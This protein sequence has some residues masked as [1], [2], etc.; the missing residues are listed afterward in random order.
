M[1]TFKNTSAGKMEK[2]MYAINPI[3]KLPQNLLL[4]D[5][6][7]N[8][9]THFALPE[10]IKETYYENASP[11]S[12]HENSMKS[13][14]A[15]DLIVR[16]EKILE[17]LKKIK[18]KLI[19]LQQDHRPNEAIINS[20]KAISKTS[21]SDGDFESLEENNE[22]E[23]LD[24]LI[25]LKDELQSSS[26]RNIIVENEKFQELSEKHDF[27]LEIILSLQNLLASDI[28][29]LQD[30]TKKPSGICLHE[31]HTEVLQ[32]ISRLRNEFGQILDAINAEREIEEEDDIGF[33][34]YHVHPLESGEYDFDDA[35]PDFG[36]KF[37]K[38]GVIEDVVVCSDS[39]H[40][41]Y[42][43]LALKNLLGPRLK[44]C[45]SSTVH[46]SSSQVDQNT[47][48][49]FQDKNLRDRSDFDVA[50]TVI[51]KNQKFKSLMVN[52]LTQCA[53]IGEGNILRYLSRLS[54]SSSPLNYESGDLPEVTEVDYWLDL[55]QMKLL[56]G[57]NKEQ[58]NALKQL[59]S[60]LGSSDWLNGKQFGVCDIFL[61][62]VL[63]Q[64]DQQLSSAAPS[65]VGSWMKKISKIAEFDIEGESFIPI[66]R[67]QKNSRTEDN[68][69]AF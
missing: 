44:V 64:L 46:S 7:H 23:I 38:S 22:E 15:S 31:H 45:L 14:A 10:N 29:L 51:W 56:H 69:E 35:S 40:P 60:K 4:S 9:K 68:Q 54:P 16:Q 37:L 57:N 13:E 12:C 11:N 25:M 48:N 1:L 42:F 36:Q 47:L 33:Q 66:R 19:H 8:V 63:K 53:I 55:M 41:P 61:W 67:E 18:E 6:M 30:D 2:K 27:V 17:T 58:Q 26:K 28:P 5:V 59:N 39:A 21:V 24:H 43:L 3:V 52:P 32:L 49:L 62:S 34:N 20:T 50:F 65:N